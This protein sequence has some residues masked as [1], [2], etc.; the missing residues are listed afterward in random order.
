MTHRVRQPENWSTP[1]TICGRECCPSVRMP[2]FGRSVVSVPP[3]VPA[4]KPSASA[5]PQAAASN[6]APNG[7]TYRHAR[8]IIIFEWTA[9]LCAPPHPPP[10]TVST[11]TVCE[12]SISL[13]I[14]SITSTRHL[15]RLTPHAHT[16][17]TTHTHTDT[18]THGHTETMAHTHTYRGC[19]QTPASRHRDTIRHECALEPLMVVVLVVVVLV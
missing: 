15:C 4:A 11:T 14:N 2:D 5:E 17:T 7:R 16:D 18:P 10:E 8:V 12:C 9:V 3:G 19:P 1:C 13:G 6:L